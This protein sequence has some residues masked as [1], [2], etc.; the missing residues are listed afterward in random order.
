MNV[1]VAD[2]EAVKAIDKTDNERV[3]IACNGME[4]SCEF[5]RI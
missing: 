4:A 1:T 5:G 2:I 3:S